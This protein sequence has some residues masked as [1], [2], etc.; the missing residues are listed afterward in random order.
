MYVH[1]HLVQFYETDMMGIVHHSNYLRIIEEARVGW[2]HSV[3]LIDYN[4]PHSA[5]QFA[6]LEV[7]VKHLAPA[8]FGDVVEVD[9]QVRREGIRLMFQYRLRCGQK[10]LALAETH[11]V[12][13]DKNLR[14]VRLSDTMKSVLEREKW[15][16]TWL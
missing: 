10:I 12:P 6:V 11:H 7:R 2:A 15:T 1:R 5:A 3:G 14:P 4:Q 16:E 13:L 9:T 8:K